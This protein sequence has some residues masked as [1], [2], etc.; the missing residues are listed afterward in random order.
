MNYG[1][2]VKKTTQKENTAGY[3]C[4]QTDTYYVNEGI[5]IKLNVV[6]QRFSHKGW[7]ILAKCS[8]NATFGVYFNW[9][10]VWY[11]FLNIYR[12]NLAASEK[13]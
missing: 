4:I 9:K 13:Q 8:H 2:T 7:V 5:Q 10:D 1:S 11:L 6:Q 3:N 12:W